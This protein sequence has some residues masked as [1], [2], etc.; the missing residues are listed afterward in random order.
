MQVYCNSAKYESAFALIEILVAI[1]LIGIFAAIAA[2]NLLSW[3]DSRRVE[4][5]VAQIEGAIKETQS[6]SIKRGQICN[7]VIEP[8]RLTAIPTN[9]L[10]R[11]ERDLSRLGVKVLQS[12][13][14]GVGMVANFGIPPSISGAPPAPAGTLGIIRFSH[15]GTTF[16]QNGGGVLT[17][18]QRNN[19]DGARK[20][21]VVV[22]SGIGI[23]RPGRYVG[24]DPKNPVLGQCKTTLPT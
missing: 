1:L 17:I 16:I 5:V 19:P 18:F 21:C 12:N 24:G 6:E 9:C 14:T 15:R 11:G 22:T 10:P 20:R 23:V 4:D 13:Q 2:P 7:L 8:A 3:I